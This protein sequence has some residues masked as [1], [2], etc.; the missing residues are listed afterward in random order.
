[1]IEEKEVKKLKENE[2]IPLTRN[3]MFIQV[4]YYHNG[5]RRLEK[6]LA[7]Y[8]NIDYNEVKGKIELM[9]REQEQDSKLTA[10]TQVDLL[11][12]YN[13]TTYDI[14]LNNS[15]YDGLEERNLVFIS[16]IVGSK[17]EKSMEYKDIK[18]AIL[19]DINNF[20]SNGE[21]L[22]EEYR[23]TNVK[24]LK[25]EYGNG[26]LRVDVIDLIKGNNKNYKPKDEREEKIIKWCRL[27][28]CKNIVDFKKICDTILNKEESE[29]F[30]VLMN[31]LSSDSEII[32]LE[33]DAERI[34]NG[35]ISTYQRKFREEGIKEGRKEGIEQG[36]SQN[37]IETAKKM[38]EDKLHIETIIK[39]NNLSLKEIEKLK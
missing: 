15:Y 17:Y 19:I 38:L 6:F 18:P 39:Y 29:R 30:V 13:D 9:P 24:N 37:K 35:F 5:I 12:K 27:F 34:H 1:M 23:L 25:I 3:F 8:L 20:K 28:K 33:G 7:D 32:K 31:K 11:F 2:I 26:N 16:K 21:D 14:K 10:E 22:I 36:K 4:F